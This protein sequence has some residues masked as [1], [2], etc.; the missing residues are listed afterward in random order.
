MTTQHT[1]GPWIAEPADMF[2][3][4]NIVLRDSDDCRAVAAVVSNM[5]PEAEVAGNAR[6]IAASP[7]LLALAYQYLS[8]LRYPPIG[9][10]VQ[11]RLERA[12]QVIA[13]ATAK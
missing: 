2:G 5:R 11:R 1:P 13:K 10:S 8:D 6:L 7:D 12:A 9:D 4:H 3:D